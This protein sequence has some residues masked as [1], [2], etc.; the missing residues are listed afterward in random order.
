MR[1]LWVGG[2]IAPFAAPIVFFLVLLL[3]SVAKDGWVLGM[4]SWETGIVSAVVFVLPVSYL[5]TWFLG[6]PYIYWL[7][8]KSRLSM[9][10]VCTVAVVFG[11]V[12][13]WVF[14]AFGKNGSVTWV[15]L[16][17]GALI[18]AL[19]AVCVALPLCWIVG[20]PTRTDSAR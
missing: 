15:Q 6:M 1:P 4:Q 5:A 2:L 13:M 18:G 7:R 12:S 10:R 14:Q 8:Q 11:A 16:I 3:L 19:L 17:Q 9:L 20:I